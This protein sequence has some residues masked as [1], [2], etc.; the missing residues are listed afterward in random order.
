M[1]SPLMSAAE[2][3]PGFGAPTRRQ[4]VEERARI[5]AFPGTALGRIALWFAL[6]APV[7]AIAML[8]SPATTGTVNAALLERVAQIPLDRADVSWL[9]LL[10]P[11][12]T[13]LVA[14][15]VAPGGPVALAL[16]GAFAAGIVLT[17]LVQLLKQRRMPL[18][19]IVV[20][21]AALAANPLFFY[22]ATT[23]LEGFLGTA[24]FGLALAHLHRFVVWRNTQSGFRAGMLLLLATLSSPLGVVYAVLAAAMSTFLELARRGERGVR[25]ANA[26]IVI[27][28]TAS[29]LGAVGLLSI[30]FL[31][32]PFAWVHVVD[33]EGAGARGQA[34]LGLSGSP[35]GWL[36]A[37]SLACSLLAAV[38]GRQ[39]RAIGAAVLLFAGVLSGFVVGVLPIEAAG[40]TFLVMTL[41]AIVLQPAARRP[42]TAVPLVAVAAL[43]GA[44]AWLTAADRG[45]TAEW[46]RG[47]AE[48]VAAL[49]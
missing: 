30:V 22:N 44:V 19:L 3:A 45:L 32:D 41:A 12:L 35:T 16:I 8:S 23:N 6:A 31:G 18:P 7:F 27:F 24:F 49:L 39:P 13:T 34:L 17:E 38:V 4:V 40:T 10:Y 43:Q 46:L 29:V 33:L 5:A 26:L 47:I 14:A 42:A 21:L 11:P 28:P 2:L 1:A 37:A 15:A 25:F 20:Q 48:T 9:G 36:L